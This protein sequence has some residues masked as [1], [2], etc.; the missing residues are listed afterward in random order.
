MTM[1]L[2]LSL[3]A[4]IP[5]AAASLPLFEAGRKTVPGAYIVEYEDGHV[6]NF[7]P[8]SIDD[9]LLTTVIECE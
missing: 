8:F 3:L 6:G 1:R 2:V 9:P 5:V 4:G 7:Q